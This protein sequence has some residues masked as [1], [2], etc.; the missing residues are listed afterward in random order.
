MEFIAVKR[1]GTELGVLRDVRKVDVDIGTSNDFIITFDAANWSGNEVLTEADYWYAEGYGELGGRIQCIKSATQSKQVQLS[2]YVW[3]GLLAKKIIEPDAGMDYKT[4]SGE[5]NTVLAGLITSRFGGFFTVSGEDS[6][7]DVGTYQFKRYCTLL[8]G[9]VDMLHQVGAR[10]DISY[11]CGTYELGS[12]V[13]GAVVIRAVPIVDYSDEIEYSQDGK[14]DFVAK[15]YRMGVNHL[16]CLGQGDLKERQVVHLYMDSAGTVST[17]QSLFGFEEITEVY[18]YSSA[19]STEELIKGGTARLR[20]RAN[21][22]KLEI[23]LNDIDAEIGDIV[24]GRERVTG[25]ALKKQIKNI[26]L[27]IDSKGR[28]KITHKVGD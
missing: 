17:E 1:D 3:R 14:I 9:I 23:A 15:D 21:Y 8:D 24:G 5:A 2:G 16:I 12:Y 6:G 10:I 27:K 22:K 18:D 7:I 4:V 26:I 25:I 28:L 13:P 20:E 11:R 19:E